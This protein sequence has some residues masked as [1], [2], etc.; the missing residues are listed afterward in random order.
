M[1]TVIISLNGRE[2]SGALGTTVLD[3]A[4][5]AGVEIPTLCHHPLL[6]NSGACRVCLVEEAKS[7]RVLASCV[8]P[9][10]DGMEILTGSP[11]A[12][13][14]RRGVLELILSDHPSACVICSKGN[15]CVLRSLAKEHGIC[16]PDLDPIRRWRPIQEVNPFIVR[17]LTKCVMC[18]RCI[19]VCRDF[20]VVGAVEY[21]DRGYATHPGTA[22]RSPL[23]GSECNFCGSCV[24]I[25]PTDALAEKEKPS[26]SSGTTPAQGI[27][28][29]CGTGCHLQYELLN[30]T[31]VAAR[32]VPASPVNSLSL[33]VRGHYGQDAFCSPE[34]LVVP[35]IRDADD[36]FRA[37]AWEEALDQVASRLKQIIE[38]DGPDRVGI[39]A[40]TQCSNEEFYLVSKFG[41]L[42]LGTPNVDSTAR[43]SSGTVVAG[44]E[45]SLRQTLTGGS[46]DR[47]EHAE[48]IVLIGARPDYTHPVVARNIRRAVRN[49]YAA[50]IQ[51]D[52]L[53]TS[54]TPF[55]QICFK[56]Q[57]DAL[58]TIL[59]RLTREIV[60]KSLHDEDFLRGNIMNSEDFLSGLKPQVEDQTARE[61]LK[62]AAKLMGG[63][64]RTVFLIGP[65]VAKIT[66]GYILT[67]LAINLAMVCGQPD[68]LLFLFPGC[69]EAGTWLMGCAP[70][71]LPGTLG[72]QGPSAA[73]ALRSVWGD[74]FAFDRGLDAMEMI[75]SA[76]MKHL[77]AILFL[78]ADPLAVFP[79]TDRTRKALSGLELVMRSG[80]FS[81]VSGEVA[82]IVLPTATITEMDGTYV[83]I[84]GR[85]QLVTKIVDPPGEARPCARVILDLSG[86]FGSPM[87]FVKASDI[88]DE[89]RTVYPGWNAFTWTDL[90]EP[91][92]A[93]LLEHAGSGFST[94]NSEPGPRLV[95]FTAPDSFSPPMAAPTDRPWKVFPEENLAHPGDGVASMR[96]DRL[97]KFNSAAEVRMN[98]ADAEK[99]NAENG[100]Q[101]LVRSE[102]GEVWVKLVVDPEVPSSGV[103]VPAGGPQYIVE[104]LLGWPEEYCPL[105]WDRLFVSIASVEEE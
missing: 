101:V 81:A 32:G 66:H 70:D 23:E 22:N 82:D 94:K 9:I 78:G 48:T 76:E 60:S 97:A 40:G 68:N 89:I 84:E 17:D 53:T 67:R 44:T 10:A 12:V 100:S 35:L 11:K 13:Q 39:V 24:S 69:N 5:R 20:E 41:R 75:R 56:E 3:V 64:R 31:I 2:L 1:E 103:V 19:R 18:G 47:I 55:A 28:S 65:R 21:I 50:L 99:I 72:S 8:T 52:P 43:F 96:S 105:S 98:P 27:C 38:R 51:L 57:I 4:K 95:A 29:Y 42:I 90:K 30:E 63:G 62:Q 93:T 59:E 92:G 87:G 16:D 102:V 74:H 83:N 25:C 46:L 86:L 91:G 49:N 85:V 80:A 6:K 77:K 45:A 15:G 37:A 54:L 88:F 58:P 34:R 14:A 79:D 71:R 61:K 7:G 73:K 36:G 26:R 33:C 104:K